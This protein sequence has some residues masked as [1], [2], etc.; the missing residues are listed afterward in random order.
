MAH[1]EAPKDVLVSSR[2][3]DENRQNSESPGTSQGDHNLQKTKRA[4]V[5]V[6]GGTAGSVNKFMCIEL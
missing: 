3:T 2:F 6:I 1:M 5:L 4:P